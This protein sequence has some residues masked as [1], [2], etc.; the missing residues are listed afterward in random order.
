MKYKVKEVYRKSGSYE[1][2]SVFETDDYDVAADYCAENY[3]STS[4]HYPVIWDTD[5]NDLADKP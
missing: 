1:R 3:E 4:S 5:K 2:E